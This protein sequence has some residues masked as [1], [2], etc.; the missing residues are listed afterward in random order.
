MA[1]NISLSDDEASKLYALLKSDLAE[2]N[3]P[4]DVRLASL[5]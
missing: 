2:G 3:F 5:Y 4:Y 1:V